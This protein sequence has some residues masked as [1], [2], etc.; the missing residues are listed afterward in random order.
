MDVL[1]HGVRSTAPPDDAPTVAGQ[2]SN[3]RAGARTH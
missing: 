1:L 2:A 3:G